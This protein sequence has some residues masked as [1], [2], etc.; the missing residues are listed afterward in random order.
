MMDDRDSE[1][2]LGFVAAAA[3]VL[4]SGVAML[5]FGWS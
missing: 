1:L 2:V 3:A 5:V 4:L